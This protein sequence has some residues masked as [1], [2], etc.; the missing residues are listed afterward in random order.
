[1]PGS[2]TGSSTDPVVTLSVSAQARCGID[3]GRAQRRHERGAGASPSSN[4]REFARPTAA[5]CVCPSRP[6]TR[7]I[8]YPTAAPWRESDRR[9]LRV[10]A[11]AEVTAATVDNLKLIQQRKVD[12]AFAL[13]DTLTRR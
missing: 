11:T 4:P 1:M 7:R 12:I 5:S 8:Y 13:A 9:A 3:P 6:A 10:Q 2:Y